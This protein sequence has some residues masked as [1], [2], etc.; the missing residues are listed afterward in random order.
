MLFIVRIA[1]PGIAG[2]RFAVVVTS[3]SIAPP[4]GAVPI[5]AKPVRLRRLVMRFYGRT[6]LVLGIL[7][8]D[9]AVA[10]SIRRRFMW[11]TPSGVPGCPHD[12]IPITDEF[13]RWVDANTCRWVTV[14]SA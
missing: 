1:G 13:Q 7:K 2:Y 5:A 6:G 8:G 9:E 14:E 4:Q 11:G 3:G 10:E 12:V